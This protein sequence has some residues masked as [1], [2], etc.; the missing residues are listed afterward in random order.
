MAGVGRAGRAHLR[1]VLAVAGPDVPGGI[2]EVTA[3]AG[4]HSGASM[5]VGAAATGEAVLARMPRAGLLHI[6]AHGHHEPESA[7]FSSV[8]LFDGPLY[9]F[10]IAPSQT[11]PDHVVLSSCDAGRTDD[12]PGGEP[13][14]LAAALL[15]S[16]VSTVIAGVS[17]IADEWRRKPW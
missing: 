6:A 16:G 12:R 8:Q 9:G 15:R 13:L 3:V 17:R 7:L 14:G 4:L 5:L 11:L 2:D 1:G 10:D